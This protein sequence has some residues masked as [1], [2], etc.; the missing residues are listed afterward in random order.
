MALIDPEGMFN[1]DRFAL[2]SDSARFAWPFFWCAS[3]TVG[4]I[5]L[6]Y[7]K[8][9]NRAFITFHAVP[10]EEQF[11][12]WVKEYRDSFLLF[13]YEVDGQLW[14][15]W[16]TS[17]KYLPKYKLTA[18]QQTPAPNARAFIDWKNEYIER[19][20]LAY[21]DKLNGFNNSTKIPKPS[22]TFGTDRYGIG[23]GIGIG[24]G[25]PPCAPPD[26]DA[27]QPAET[28]P[29]N[30]SPEPHPGSLVPLPKRIESRD[31]PLE[32][33]QREWFA[34]WWAIYWLKRSRKPAWEKF[35]A[36]VRTPERFRRVMDATAAQKPE[37]LTREPKHRP[38]GATWLHQERWEDEVAAPVA[39][40]PDRL[41]KGQKV[42][43]DLFLE[44]QE[45]SAQ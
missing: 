34:Q 21:L 27:R 24:E 40:I 42:V 1:G 18:D 35:K 3:N 6:N 14:G 10:P 33:Q 2:M 19:K 23:I 8:V 17:E 20:K 45:R 44:S 32:N 43:L 37:M 11:W 9:A 22:E 31:A 30:P 26:G 41:S 4:R 13:V 25:K 29:E 15:Q 36:K 39:A 28:P 7:R 38:Y 16:D 12:A 5:E